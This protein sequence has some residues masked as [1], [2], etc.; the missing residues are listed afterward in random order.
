[1]N[2]FTNPNNNITP[3]GLAFCGVF[4]AMAIYVALEP[5]PSQKALAQNEVSA[6]VPVATQPQAKVEVP[7]PQVSPQPKSE[8]DSQP[9]VISQLPNGVYYVIEAK[10][11]GPITP[12]GLVHRFN[13]TVIDM[14][15]LK[16]NKKIQVRCQQTTLL[17]PMSKAGDTW[18]IDAPGSIVVESGPP[19]I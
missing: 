3:L 4:A 11:I 16:E 1:M 6:Q 13:Y 8:T 17:P 9:L 15:K 19:S 12:D 18:T 7:P 10:D 2:I 14:S 5:P